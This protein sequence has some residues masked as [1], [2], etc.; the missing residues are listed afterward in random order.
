MLKNG[1][2]FLERLQGDIEARRKR[3][4]ENKEEPKSSKELAYLM[5][6]NKKNFN[7]MSSYSTLNCGTNGWRTTDDSSISDDASSSSSSGSSF[8]SE[9][10]GKY[11]VGGLRRPY[12]RKVKKKVKYRNRTKT[13]MKAVAK[14][15]VG[16]SSKGKAV[17][18]GEDKIK[19]NGDGGGGGGGEG[20]RA[21]TPT[22]TISSG[23]SGNGEAESGSSASG[24]SEAGSSSG[25]STSESIN[26]TPT[27]KPPNGLIP[28]VTPSKS[29][30]IT[31]DICRP[32][33]MFAGWKYLFRHM[34]KWHDSKKAELVTCK[35]GR[36]V[37][38]EKYSFHQRY[39]C[40]KSLVNGG[41]N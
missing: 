21:K 23:S 35:C 8:N 16:K 4:E 14:L 34:A 32:S 24:K 41:G 3:Q 2:L 28:R 19:V 27:K 38:K 20:A 33:K 36:K 22:I 12:R 11:T 9:Y 25:S 29:Q 40:S 30:K 13:S 26:N 39:Y 5:Q 1:Y 15:V 18:K 6:A 37:R 10:R 31:C 17:N 7:T